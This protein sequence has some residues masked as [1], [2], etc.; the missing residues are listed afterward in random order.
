MWNM[1]IAP[2][3][4]KMLVASKLELTQLF[5]PSCSWWPYFTFCY[6]MQCMRATCVHNLI[7][8]PENRMQH[9]LLGSVHLTHSTSPAPRLM[10]RA[11]TD[12]LLNLAMV[13]RCS[14]WHER[15]PGDGP[16]PKGRWWSS[17]SVAALLGS[18]NTWGCPD[19]L[20]CHDWTT[21]HAYTNCP[22]WLPNEDVEF[23]RHMQAYCLP[24]SFYSA[25]HRHIH[26][27]LENERTCI[28]IWNR[29]SI[30]TL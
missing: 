9:A 29:T 17:R 2:Y 7:C 16:A 22:E 10:Q 24:H 1:L 13:R 26:L 14:W 5:L 21:A 20:K 8:R 23:R 25:A 3:F 30:C 11:G 18:P 4:I 6:Q 12:R 19:Q 27:I 15:I 28:W